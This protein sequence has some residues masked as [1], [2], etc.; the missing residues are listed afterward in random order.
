VSDR[1]RISSGWAVAIVL[2]VLLLG[3]TAV[4]AGVQLMKNVDEPG[5]HPFSVQVS[6][7]LADT[8]AFGGGSTALP[9][10]KRIVVDY[11]SVRATLPS[12][13][14]L[15][16]A[17]VSTTVAGNTQPYAV[18]PTFTGTDT[19]GNDVYVAG[20]QVTLYDDPNNGLNVGCTR[21]PTAS[22]AANITFFINGH[23]LSPR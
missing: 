17:D 3:G 2:A 19:S 8:V 4:A 11:V 18:V 22:G 9:A 13:Q 21:G 5:R 20:Q 23:T 15:L 16:R 14:K 6:C 1:K 10:G 7:D 12:G